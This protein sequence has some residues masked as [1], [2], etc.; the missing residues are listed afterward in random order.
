MDSPHRPV[1]EEAADSPEEA[2]EAALIS[3]AAP[4]EVS[5]AEEAAAAV[6]SSPEVPVVSVPEVADSVPEE[7]DSAAEEDSEAAPK[8]PNIS[9]S[10][11]HPQNLKNK[12]A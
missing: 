9:T 2:K 7:E 8:S 6:D 10:M 11:W 3:E 12:S 5:Q 1:S 4:E